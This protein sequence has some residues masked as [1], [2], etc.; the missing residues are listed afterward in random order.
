[1]RKWRR[2]FSEPTKRRRLL[3]WLLPPDLRDEI[4]ELA[5]DEDDD[6][7]DD[8]DEEDDDDEDDED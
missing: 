8:Q 7:E 6:D 2:W 1:M 5:L 4:I 3:R